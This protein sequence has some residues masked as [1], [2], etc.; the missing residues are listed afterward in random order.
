[1]IAQKE[2]SLFER[3]DEAMSLMRDVDRGSLPAPAPRRVK[4]KKSLS[5]PAF[6][7]AKKEK[8]GEPPKAPQFGG[9]CTEHLT[10]E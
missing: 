2:I 7:S 9:T 10:F 1:M 4:T 5:P 8:E 6:K 3:D